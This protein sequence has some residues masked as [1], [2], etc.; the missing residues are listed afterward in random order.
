MWVLG[1]KLWIELAW[2]EDGENTAWFPGNNSLGASEAFICHKLLN[3]KGKLQIIM[4]IKAHSIQGDVAKFCGT[5]KKKMAWETNGVGR[6]CLG[7][8]SFPGRE[9]FENATGA[10]NP[11]YSCPFQ[12]LFSQHTPPQHSSLLKVWGWLWVRSHHL[13]WRLDSRPGKILDA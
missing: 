1:N 6:G 4:I 2:K 12:L 8:G 11:W 10:F 7:T 3:E 9:R 13:I 5:K